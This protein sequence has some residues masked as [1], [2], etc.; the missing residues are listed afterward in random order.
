MAIFFLHASYIS[1]LFFTVDCCHVQIFHC[2]LL[3]RSVILVF[4]SMTRCYPLHCKITTIDSCL[5]IFFTLPVILFHLSSFF[6]VIVYIRFSHASFFE[7]L[8]VEPP[9]KLASLHQL[10]PFFSSFFQILILCPF[11]CS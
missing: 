6:I 10:H 4:G 11:F 9:N 3:S 8:Q 1:L 7:T 2:W 5:S